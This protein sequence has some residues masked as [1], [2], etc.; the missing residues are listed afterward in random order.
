MTAFVTE[1]RSRPGIVR[2]GS[3]G[4][5]RMTIRVELP[6][7][8]DTIAFDARSD[9]TV[10]ALKRQALAQFGLGSEMP[11]EFVIKLRGFEVRDEDAT[12]TDT[13]ALAG[14]TFLLSWRRR[15]PVR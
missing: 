5:T 3:E 11:E 9:T 10:S 7:Q 2:L 14:S 12:L 15:R 8:W 13:G 6:E 4:G 1:L